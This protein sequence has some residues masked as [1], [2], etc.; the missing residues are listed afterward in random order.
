MCLEFG[1]ALLRRGEGSA[2]EAGGNAYDTALVDRQLALPVYIALFAVPAEIHFYFAADGIAFRCNRSQRAVH[3]CQYLAVLD[4]VYIIDAA[5]AGYVQVDAAAV[6]TDYIA[7]ESVVEAEV[8]D[9]FITGGGT[10]VAG[11]ES[12]PDGVAGQ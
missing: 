11:A 4:N 8:D 7:H 9:D 1:F 12:F 3:A 6:A 5:F 2:A 10:Y